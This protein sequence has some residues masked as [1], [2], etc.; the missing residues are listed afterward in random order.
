MAKFQNDLTQGSVTKNLIRFSLPFLAA[1]FL[2]AMYNLSDMVIVGNFYGADGASAV[3]VGGQLTLLIINIVSGIAIGGT[4]IIA[5]L[6]GSKREEALGRTLGTIF[7]LYGIAALFFTAVMLFLNPV[8]LRLLTQEAPE[9]YPDAL[10]YVNICT[11]GNIFIFGYNAVSAVLRGMG[12]SKHPLI[13]VGVAAAG[14]ILLDLLLVG[15]LKMGAAGAAVATVIAQAFSFILSIVYLKKKNFVFD[16]KP[17]SF[18][19]HKDTASKILRIGLPAALQGALVTISFMAL[20]FVADKV[21]AVAGT[22]AISVV[23][24]VN[25]LAILPA[26]A[27]QMSVSSIAGQNFGAKKPERALKTMFVAI[28]LTFSIS[29]V[30]YVAV[31]IF[32]EQIVSL[33]I[34]GDSQNLTPEQTRE[35]ILQSAVYLKNMSLDYLIVSAVFNIG[36][37]AMAAGQTWYSLM[38]SIISSLALRVPAA[39]LLGMT[40]NYGMAGLGYAAP[41]ASV[42]ALIIGVVYICSGTWKRKRHNREIMPALIDV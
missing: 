4:V 41:I 34:G 5:R 17:K 26:L 6:L 29:L 18:R 2:Q 16:F 38:I 28:G 10:R 22:T 11:A 21:A 42:G 15:P 7:S 32:P 37:F 14:N 27:M 12:D 31:Q 24:K 13:F 39:V 19:I 23:G 25:S 3:G 35:C 33:F 36:G 30:V 40:F 8:I 1:N 9:V 20:T